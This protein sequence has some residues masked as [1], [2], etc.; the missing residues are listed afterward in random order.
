MTT[1]KKLNF[2]FFIS[3]I[4][5]SCNYHPKEKIIYSDDSYK[6]TL[7]EVSDGE[8]I[9]YA[10]NDSVL[11]LADSTSRT[12][13]SL[14]G[15][16]VFTSPS[17]LLNVLYRVAVND[18]HDLYRNE[19][20]YF[21]AGESPNFNRKLIFT[22]DISY[23]SFLGLAYLMPKEVIE[24]LRITRKYRLRLGFLHS[25]GHEIPIKGVPNRLDDIEMQEFIG[26]YG[27]NEFA[28]RTDDINWFIGWYQCWLVERNDNLLEEMIDMYYKCDSAF[29]RYFYN[30]EKGLYQGQASFIDI[31]RSG[32]PNLT[33]QESI[34]IYALSTN[35]LYKYVF[36]LLS[37][38][39]IYL[40][41]NEEANTFQQKSKKLKKSIEKNF[42]HPDGF[43][44]YFMH[45]NGNLEPRRELL[46]SA[47]IPLFNI[48]NKNNHCVNFKNYPRK[49]YGSILMAPPFERRGSHNDAVWPFA[50][51]FFD[52][53]RYNK[54]ENKMKVLRQ[55][56]GSLA[57]HAFEGSFHEF[58][59]FGDGK[60]R[61][62]PAYIWSNAAYI[63]TLTR[64]LMGIELNVDNTISVNPCIPEELDGG[65]SWKN[66]QIGDM[67]LD[68]IINGTGQTIHSA[69]WDNNKMKKIVIPI[70]SGKHILKIEMA[71]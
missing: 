15:K 41:R 23:S 70:K 62:S 44:A 67:Q 43:W 11:V 69:K 12:I 40:G 64:M 3:L 57:Y 55:S 52:L 48:G 8:R 71:D 25:Q 59:N 16:P 49:Y 4:P 10:K 46:S 37:N 36:D 14:S 65:I 27:T 63:N 45:S 6:V 24:H 68:I 30:P 34:K 50:D 13:Q 33:E 31:G 1:F 29:Y 42:W 38:A 19:G 56:L 47:F 21:V 22:R 54:C 17:A 32:Y 2:I 26:K 66:I 9:A 60:F 28:R 39:C 53:A 61:G 5:I 20:G 7:T 35:A 18:L 58:L 51:S